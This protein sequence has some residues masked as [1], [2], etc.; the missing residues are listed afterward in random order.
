MKV[1]PPKGTGFQKKVHILPL[2]DNS[3]ELHQLDRTNSVSWNLK[4]SPGDADSATYKCQVRVLGGL[5]VARQVLRW[6]ADVRK[7]V[8]GLNVT[9]VATITPIHEACMR[10]GPMA[11]YRHAINTAKE[12]LYNTAMAQAVA[13]DDINNQTAAAAALAM[14]QPV[15]PNVTTAADAVM[16]TGKDA[17]IQTT[18]LDAALGYVVEQ[19][20]PRKVLAKVKRDMRREMRKPADMKVRPYY[21]NLT[22]M[23]MEEIPQL[24]PYAQNQHLNPDEFLD[25]LLFGT[26]KS[27]QVEME[28]QGFDPIKKGVHAAMEFMENIE[29]AEAHEKSK[30]TKT[31]SE[32]KKSKK[33]VKFE[34]NNQKGKPTH[35]CTEHG[36]N[37]THD[38]KD[39]NTL[40]KKKAGKWKT[41]KKK[42][43]GNKT[44]TRKAEEET[45][46]SKKDLAAFVTKV[47]KKAVGK[48]EKKE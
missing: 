28:R 19:V 39:C 47:A 21:N 17:L 22:R 16:R 1:V 26:P 24:P 45:T 13:A 33:K 23:N 9:T 2:E 10:P 11:L 35:F 25:V 43:Y 40:A 6:L 18:H 14:G 37:Y 5:E 30:D 12:N 4:T 41:D 42:P 46:V 38:T 34:G 48:K 27:W 8:V 29:A 15:P 44:W 7:V 3:D 32:N 36:P 20:L 31:P